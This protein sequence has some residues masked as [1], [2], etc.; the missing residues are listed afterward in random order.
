M[1]GESKKLKDM[2]QFFRENKTK[3]NTET[4]PSL[5]LRIAN[6]QCQAGDGD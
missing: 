1:R 4:H 2:A 5:A 6:F 3:I